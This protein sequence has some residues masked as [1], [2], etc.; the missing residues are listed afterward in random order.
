[1]IPEGC[2]YT[3]SY[4]T[5]ASYSYNPGPSPWQS[6]FNCR[7]Q[8]AQTS[9]CLGYNWAPATNSCT[10]YYSSGSSFVTAD[11]IVLSRPI[12]KCGKLSF[13]F[14]SVWMSCLALSQNKWS[15]LWCPHFYRHFKL[16][17]QHALFDIISRRI[18]TFL[19][20]HLTLL[21]DIYYY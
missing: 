6:S 8:C 13:S 3:F 21:Q 14:D 17:L 7:I 19:L 4:Q 15:S 11:F 2:L 16:T 12:A 18:S 9:S 20:F 5:G 1:M 10:W